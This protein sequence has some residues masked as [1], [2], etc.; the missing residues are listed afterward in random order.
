MPTLDEVCLSISEETQVEGEVKKNETLTDI[1]LPHSV[2]YQQISEIDMKQASTDK[3]NQN[4]TR[5]DSRNA[6]L[7]A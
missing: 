2:S 5:G 4:S 3:Y 7:S 1:L 6:G